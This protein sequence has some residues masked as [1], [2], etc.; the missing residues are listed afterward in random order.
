[1]KYSPKNHKWAVIQSGQCVFGTGR[2]RESAIRDA[3]KWMSQ[4]IFYNDGM[5]IG[6]HTQGSTHGWLEAVL[7]SNK[8][9]DGDVYITNDSDDIRFY[10][11]NQ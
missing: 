5:R 11:E 8:H 4:P 7:E 9:V 1:M 3:E 6:E 10:V 2:T